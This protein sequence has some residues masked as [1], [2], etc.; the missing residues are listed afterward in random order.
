MS[1]NFTRELR[2]CGEPEAESPQ[3]SGTAVG[4]AD[5]RPIDWPGPARIWRQMAET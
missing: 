1:V 4:R 3:I 5:S 2:P